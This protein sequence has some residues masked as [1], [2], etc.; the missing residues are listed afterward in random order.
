VEAGLR[1]S[2]SSICGRR[3][4]KKKRTIVRRYRSPLFDLL[5]ICFD[6]RFIFKVDTGGVQVILE[7]NLV[8]LKIFLA[9]IARLL[10]TML[11]FVYFASINGSARRIRTL[12]QLAMKESVDCVS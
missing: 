6:T 3:R 9:E 5:G 8:E 7:V 2:V 10:I 1:A 4:G 11:T 12:D